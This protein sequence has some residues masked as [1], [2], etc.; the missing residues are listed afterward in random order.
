MYPEIF[1]KEGLIKNLNLLKYKQ[2]SIQ[3]DEKH[4]IFY[5]IKN[6][7]KRK[8]KNTIYSKFFFP[9]NIVVVMIMEIFNFPE[10]PAG[11]INYEIYD[12]NK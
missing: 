9:P 6:L 1:F 3:C 5:R 11:P 8:I 12:Y 10:I 4:Y 2:H 7:K